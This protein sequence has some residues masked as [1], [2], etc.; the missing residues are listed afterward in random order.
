MVADGKF[1]ARPSQG[2]SKVPL[3]P[4]Q[5]IYRVYVSLDGKEN[6]INCGNPPAS[7]QAN[8]NCQKQIDQ[9]RLK[10]NSILGVNIY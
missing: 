3:L 1:T 2:F 10:L 6:I 8:I 9:L 5:A 4:D 7:T